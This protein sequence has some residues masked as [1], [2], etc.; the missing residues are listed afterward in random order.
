MKLTTVFLLLLF[1]LPLAVGL[2][3]SSLWD[4]NEAFYAQTPR[5][6]LERGDWL[7]PHFNGRPRLNK[8]PL[9]YWVV[10]GFYRVFGVS[11]YWERLAMAL[12]SIGT[13]L[14]TFALGRFLFNETVA[15]LGAGV[16]ATGFRFLILSR[17]LM[18]DVLLL[19]CLTA[20]LA[21]FLIWLKS[22]RK[23][24]FLGTT[25]A[26]SLGFLTKG[27]VIGVAVL[28]ALAILLVQGKSRQ[29]VGV[30]W[31]A[32]TVLVLLLVPGWFLLVAGEVGWDPVGAFFLR[33]NLGRFSHL[34]FGPERGVF[35]YLGV[36]SVDFFPWSLLAAAGLFTWL[37]QG[38]KGWRDQPETALLVWVAV[39]LAVFSLSH[40]KQEYYVL[41]IYPALALWLGCQVQQARI[42]RWW[43]F[44]AGILLCLIGLATGLLATD[45]FSQVAWPYL[46]LAPFC[47]LGF[48]LAAWRRSW[49]LCIL[50]LSL[51]LAAVF[52]VY[53]PALEA[54]RPT[55]DLARIIQ[56]QGAAAGEAGYFGFTA[57]S[58]V[59]Y[60]NR[61]VHELQDLEEAA[62]L[63]DRLPSLFLVIREEDWG[64]LQQRTQ[65]QLRIV[66][67]RPQLRLN[68]DLLI[69]GLRSSYRD[70]P[71]LWASRIHLIHNAE[72][73]DPLPPSGSGSFSKRPLM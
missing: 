54:Y 23:W 4:S 42:N 13:V 56:R 27:P 33:E 36:I 10:G 59:F 32:A 65:R 51:S 2:D 28:S 44:S 55:R 38:R 16:L 57:P 60:L 37:R 19:F 39:W 50:S 8:P 67:T 63:L 14:T 5:E 25:L 1:C 71:S 3:A 43:W 7:I 52:W 64:A 41:P 45:L 70:R 48:P 66:A 24:A 17:R 53:L 34:D 69:R 62:A 30:P 29:L 15:L 22:G 68:G 9:A 46:W 18:I 31:L 12:L 6:M 11:V 35:Y 72:N 40:N 20:A 73:S 49:M 58:L 26:L 21:F 47:L 61:P